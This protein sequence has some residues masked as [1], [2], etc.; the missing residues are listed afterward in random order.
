MVENPLDLY[1]RL[2]KDPKSLFGDDPDRAR[3]QAL[4]A[5]HP[6]RHPF[7]QDRAQ[8]LAAAIGAAYDDLTKPK[9]L[10]IATRRTSYT[11]DGPA[12]PGDLANLY[13]SGNYLLKMPRSS[14]DNDLME[15]EA[16]A[17][18]LL[19]EPPTEAEKYSAYA[20]RLV[21]TFKHKDQS[22]ILRR[23][24]VLE[25]LD[26]GFIP[27]TAVKKAY[28]NGLG[29]RDIAWI[30]R[31]LLVAIGYAQR[32]G[33]VHGAITPEHV[34][35][36]PI[37]HGVMLIDWCYS[38]IEDDQRIPAL[39]PTRDFFYPPEVRDKGKPTTATDIYTAS[40]T[41]TWLGGTLMP[42]A[43][44]RFAEGSAL[45]KQGMRPQDAWRLQEEYD[46]LLAMLY[47][48]RAYRP[49]KMPATVAS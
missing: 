37:K 28:P 5:V 18:K 20:E 49:L 9:K 13:P 42:Q 27:L 15:R 30:W 14:H 17:L 12:I 3:K 48:Q 1:E 39:V 34:M 8:K 45:V 7:E 19:A 6:D 29:G 46:G 38:C 32:C 2:L 21:E 24:N 40:K 35:V 26:D 31:R 10:V 22:G 25:R 4:K 43:M 47:G 41:M 11:I 33:V 16:R 23:V 36:H 44:R